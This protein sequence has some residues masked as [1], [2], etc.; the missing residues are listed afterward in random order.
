MDYAPVF[1]IILIALIVKL[2]AYAPAVVLLPWPT[3]LRLWVLLSVISASLSTVLTV[4]IVIVL[5]GLAIGQADSFMGWGFGFMTGLVVMAW[6]YE[7]VTFVSPMWS[8]IVQEVKDWWA[9]RRAALTA[10]A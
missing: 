3:H 7:A 6:V 2:V 8:L 10:Q 5:Q 9:S 4:V 1:W